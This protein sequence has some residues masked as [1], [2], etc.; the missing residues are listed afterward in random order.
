MICIT[1]KDSKKGKMSSESTTYSRCLISGKQSL[2]RAKRMRVPTTLVDNTANRAPQI[3]LW[4]ASV[5]KMQTQKRS[6]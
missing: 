2:P 3:M 5:K 6:Q 1:G 4:G